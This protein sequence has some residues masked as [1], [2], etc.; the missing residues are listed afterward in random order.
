[1]K[2]KKVP[3]LTFL[4]PFDNFI[5]AGKLIIHV[6]GDG[7]FSC[8]LVATLPLFCFNKFVKANKVHNISEI[9]FVILIVMTLWKG[10]N[11]NPLYFLPN[12]T[13]NRS[14]SVLSISICAGVNFASSSI[15]HSTYSF[16][17]PSRSLIVSNPSEPLPN[18]SEPFQTIHNGFFIPNRIKGYSLNGNFIYPN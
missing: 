14:K 11:S 13:R 18:P 2:C 5:K 12:F 6:K 1:M 8:G 10:N 16:I 7:V 3:Q 17:L 15:S 9:S 4:I